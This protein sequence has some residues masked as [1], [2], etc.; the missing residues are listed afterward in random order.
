MTDP[1]RL[2]D[3]RPN[4]G[5]DPLAVDIAELQGDALPADQ[6]A[7]P[8][9]DQIE[10]IREATLSEQEWGTT[11]MPDRQLLASAAVDDPMTDVDELVDDELRR[12]LATGDTDVQSLDALTEGEFRDGETTDV[13]VAIEEGEVWIPP[14]D[15]PTVPSDD[16]QGIQIA[17]GT[18]VSADDEPYDDDHRS[19][20]LD[21][22]G[23][24]N[25]RVREAL[26]ADA[27]TTTLADRLEIAVVGS[28]AIIRGE[29]DGIEDS[30]N[31]IEGAS[32]VEGIEDVLDETEVAGL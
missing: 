25:A 2:P 9:D 22:E 3:D 1:R 17:A 6:D 4:I 10:G 32:R 18:G 16:P 23:S 29:I 11:P 24:M 31:L 15:P 12:G 13:L 14:S 20:E 30:D 5:T 8:E 27:A 21:E 28:T 19:G 26:R 7:V